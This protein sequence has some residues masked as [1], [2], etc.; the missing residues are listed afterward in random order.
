MSY[1]ADADAL[2]AA[3][4]AFR[5]ACAALGLEPRAMLHPRDGRRWEGLP[6]TH[7]AD[8]GERCVLRNVGEGDACVVLVRVASSCTARNMHGRTCTRG[9][10]H[11]GP[12]SAYVNDTWGDPR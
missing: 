5:S 12:H 11:S 8:D 9:D 3:W 7:E 1:E 6:L 10:G 4:E 2:R